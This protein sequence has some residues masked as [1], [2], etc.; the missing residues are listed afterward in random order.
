M[1]KHL[2]FPADK[3]T[4]ASA[5]ACD[6]G[7]PHAGAKPKDFHNLPGYCLTK[8]LVSLQ[9]QPPTLVSRPATSEPKTPE[10]ARGAEA[11][12]SAAEA[13]PGAAEAAPGAT[14]E[15]SGHDRDTLN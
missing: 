9:Q 12:P 1:G 14:S 4:D 10:P 15:L 6:D 11:A 13:A 8:L 5:A 3:L 7:G 2:A